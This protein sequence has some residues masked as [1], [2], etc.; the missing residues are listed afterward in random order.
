MA[1]LVAPPTPEDFGT[2]LLGKLPFEP[3]RQQTQL[4]AALAR[5][6]TSGP[7]EAVF[8]LN[9]YA[10][11]GKTSMVG[12]LVKTLQHYRVPTV[13]LAPTG[14]A[15]KVFASMAGR[16]AY[17]I[18][19]HIYRMQG[20]DGGFRLALNTKPGTVFIVDEA[21]MISNVAS[22]LTGGSLLEDL[23]QHVFTSDGCRLVLLGD[24]AQLPPV[25]T[26][27]SPALDLKYMRGFGLP[28]VRAGMTATVRQAA[29]SGILV[30][31]TRLRTLMAAKD[32]R[33][34]PPPQISS[35][36]FGD[37]TDVDSCD[38][39]D[40]LAGAYRRDGVDNTILITR[41]NFAATQANLII[42]NQVLG[43]E[44]E[45]VRGE[46][47]MVVK[48]NYAVTRKVP[49][50][51]FIANG[52]SLIVRAIHGMESLHG[53]RFANVTVGLGDDTASPDI[54]CKILLDTLTSNS[55]AA[56]PA[57]WRMFKERMIAELGS[58]APRG[59]VAALLREDPYIN[60]L[61]VKYAYAVTCHKAQG[62]QWINVFLDRGALHPLPDED[63]LDTYRWVYTAITRATRRLYMVGHSD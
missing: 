61:Q 21:S 54:D 58:D 36:G 62:G 11:T 22:E 4:T 19:R 15:A 44:E 51:D 1:S 20:V 14:R 43:Y 48:N 17:T 16:N 26:S 25:G 8:M 42:R 5:F 45:L 2:V 59:A 55:P 28:V 39:A 40:V 60:A 49:G 3:T 6:F 24:T 9:G 34:L 27:L 63:M 38:L 41:A 18:H 37:V 7:Q 57:A 53:L 52:D 47:L 30:N 13:L 31:A 23:L 10:G 32:N 12:A 46:R 56:D 50:V 33:Q 35:R 29:N